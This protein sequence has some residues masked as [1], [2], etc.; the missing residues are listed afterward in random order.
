MDTKYLIES[1]NN[2]SK[3][4]EKSNAN[5]I[6]YFYAGIKGEDAAGQ[7]AEKDLKYLGINGSENKYN[8]YFKYI[9]IHLS[10]EYETRSPGFDPWIEKIPWQKA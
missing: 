1:Y 7:I 5:I 2:G 3:D 8:T 10:V 6:N 9:Y 4:N